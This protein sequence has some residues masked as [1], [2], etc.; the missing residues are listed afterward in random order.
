MILLPKDAQY[1]KAYCGTNFCKCPYMIKSWPPHV[2]NC[3]C[4]GVTLDDIIVSP[5]YKKISN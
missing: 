1:D 4:F 2:F 5:P 3:E